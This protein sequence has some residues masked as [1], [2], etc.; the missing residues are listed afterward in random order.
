[1][2]RKP[3]LCLLTAW[4]SLMLPGN[5]FAFA[6]D[7]DDFTLQSMCQH[8][9]TESAI[10]YATAARERVRE[11][12]D[13]YARWTQRLIE[14]E[15]QAALRAD[16]AADVHWKRCQEIIDEFKLERAQDRRL[17]WLEWQAIRCD[18]LLAQDRLA[19]WL[20]APANG[21]MREKALELV[22]TILSDLTQLE[23]DLKQRQPLA[24]KLSASDRSQAPA[25]QISQLR[26]DTILTRCEAFLIR[27]RL[28]ESRSRDRVGAAANV[29]AE[30]GGLLDRTPKAWPTRAS[31]EVARAT[32]WLDLDREAEAIALLQSVVL[33][34]DDLAARV[35]AAV[36]ACEALIGQG[37]AS[38]ARAFVDRLKE[39][40]G[41]PEW[42][43]AEIRLS[44]SELSRLPTEKKQAE[45]AKLLARSNEIGAR[46]G[47]YW[48]A[49]VDSILAG[50]V[51]S[52]EV[53][54]GNL[55]EL[56]AVE[57]RQLLAAGDER[58]AIAKLI[59]SSRNELA[60]GRHDN[61]VR[62]ATQASALL[63][64]QEAWLAA[65]DAMEEVAKQSP[66]I[67]GAAGGHLSAAWN[68]SQALKSNPQD[69]QLRLR[70]V[71][72]LQDHIRLWPN[73]LTTEQATKWLHSWLSGSGSQHDLLPV[74]RQQAE[75]AVAPEQAREAI[76]AWLGIVL[77]VPKQREA[78]LV[79]VK[80][81]LADGRF[82]SIEAS[83]QVAILAATAIPSWSEAKATKALQ[84]DLNGLANIASAPLDRQW[85]TAV[86]GLLAA[87]SGDA[88]VAKNTAGNWSSTELTAEMV[89]PLA[90]A[91]V[92]AIDAW[93]T[94]EVP[95]WS[96]KIK[97]SEGQQ[98][99]LLQ[100]TRL[101]SQAIA[102]RLR[103]MQPEKLGDATAGMRALCKQNAKLGALQLHLSHVLAKQDT[104]ARRESTEIARRL[105]ANSP[106]GSDLHYAARW[107]VIRNQMLDGKSVE[108]EK[109][110]KLV[111]A[112][113]AEDSVDWRVRFA[114]LVPP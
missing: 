109:A 106:L 55:A 68:L 94:P 112:T 82:K 32:A 11:R 80:Q 13:E 52:A 45:I 77:G 99:S 64:R 5:G 43:L 40:E 81:A 39:L 88:A 42:E 1:M 2:K 67:E 12:D 110:A 63:Q 83:A 41:G 38:R 66:A 101:T 62:F 98:Q 100:S 91:M 44:L 114:R 102:W 31:L 79:I 70:Y 15:A 103:G 28:Y 29:E 57:V 107:R 17:P 48:R 58:A 78:E 18:L 111:L 47:D 51:S 37:Q 20:A 75:Q 56:V 113:L 46:Y 90:V 84:A 4:L 16:S 33:D 35:R 49:R 7:D 74:Y 50:S 53:S 72:I 36:T 105:A 69:K 87:R 27:A 96:A 71:E 76:Y 89:E 3:L 54:S 104:T 8:G 21:P 10:L 97:F 9:L 6:L 19:R 22:R 85:L 95:E 24:A 73:A 30:A 34:A 14:C 86:Y 25:Q 23:E 92:D 60:S 26:L 108:A 59:S 61:A 65:A 93:P